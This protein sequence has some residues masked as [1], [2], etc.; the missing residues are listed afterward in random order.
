MGKVYGEADRI[1]R[2]RVKEARNSKKATGLESPPLIVGTTST[3]TGAFKAKTQKAGGGYPGKKR[4]QFLDLPPI[5]KFIE[6]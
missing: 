2:K 3:F 5:K 1:R 4:G 6:D